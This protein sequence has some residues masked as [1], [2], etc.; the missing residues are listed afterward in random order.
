MLYVDGDN[1]SM[2]RDW[3][4]ITQSL[5]K[6]AGPL[7]I[8]HKVLV[9]PFEV[10]LPVVTASVFYCGCCSSVRSCGSPYMGIVH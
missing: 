2:G 4:I 3:N 6:A 9:D 1:T 5:H 10:L 8:T 7:F